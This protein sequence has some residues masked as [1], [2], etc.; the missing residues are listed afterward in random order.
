MQLWK[1]KSL[2]LIIAEEG[3]NAYH[4]PSVKLACQ[5]GRSRGVHKF[6]LDEQ[7]NMLCLALKKR[8]MLFH[9]SGNEFVELKDFSLPDTAVA[10]Q[11][12]GDSVCVG[13]KRE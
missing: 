2:L 10:L 7:R 5:A 9:H 12:V 3:L 13:F 11:W 4:F 6:A 1:A 8:L